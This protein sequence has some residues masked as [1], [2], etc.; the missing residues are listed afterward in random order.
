M[1][2]LAN[3]LPLN[4]HTTG[5]LSDKYPNLFVPAG[6]TFSIWGVIY[7]LLALYTGYQLRKPAGPKREEVD[8][9]VANVSGWYLFSSLL[10]ASWIVAWHYE[11]FPVSLAIM[12]LLLVCLLRIN[13]GLYNIQPY[14]GKTGHF[15][16][17]A[18][19]G[20]YL[21]WICVATIANVTAWLVAINWDGSGLSEVTWAFI[22]ILGGI[23]IG[24]YTAN[25]LSNGYVALGVAWAMVGIIIKRHES[26]PEYYSLMVL[27]GIGALVL[28]MYVLYSLFFS[29]RLHSQ[30]HPTHL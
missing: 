3:W 24:L 7:A 17:K 20:L 12:L 27:A 5:E 28:F 13:F 26:E 6:L 29:H 14:L 15:L 25:A 10:N 30:P 11:L 4:G 9:V 2:F 22:M 16:T 1:N 21:G 8:L 19:F 18:A 23:F